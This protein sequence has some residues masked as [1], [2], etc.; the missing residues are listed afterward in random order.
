MMKST[1]NGSDNFTPRQVA[2]LIEKFRGEFRVFGEGL[3]SLTH[4]FD[5]FEN[6]FG[7]LEKRVDGI[8]MKVEGIRTNQARTLERVTDMDF[9]MNKRF[10]SVENRIKGL[11][12][13]KI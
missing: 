11:E 10:D 6:R 9:R 1:P 12:A 2:V 7:N 4:K 5:K 8:D 13:T 3:D